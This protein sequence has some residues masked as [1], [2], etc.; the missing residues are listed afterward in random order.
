MGEQAEAAAEIGA[1]SGKFRQMAHEQRAAG[2]DSVP[3]ENSG[4]GPEA[5]RIGKPRRARGDG[6]LDRS[7]IAAGGGGADAVMAFRGF[8]GGAAELRQFLGETA[9]ALV[10]GGEDQERRGGGQRAQSESEG[11]AALYGAGR[12]QHG[13]VFERVRSCVFETG[14]AWKKRRELARAGGDVGEFRRRRAEHVGE[15]HLIPGV[16]G[17]LSSGARVGKGGSLSRARTCDK[18]INSRL[19]YQLSYQ[20]SRLR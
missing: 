16:S 7:R 1:A 2:V 13:E 6:G 20:G 15:G 11:A 5:E 9:A 10:L 4:L 12:R 14:G 8:V 18:A 19:L 3:G 17:T